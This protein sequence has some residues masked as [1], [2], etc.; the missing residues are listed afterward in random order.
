MYWLPMRQTPRY[1]G[2]N[3]FVRFS[4]YVIGPP[5]LQVPYPQIQPSMNQ[6]HWGKKFQ[7]VLKHKANSQSASNYLQ[8]IGIALD[9]I[10]NL[11]M[12]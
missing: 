7:K 8:S 11:E 5:Y 6:K 2:R 12:I 3:I 1:E 4:C 10:N 9:I